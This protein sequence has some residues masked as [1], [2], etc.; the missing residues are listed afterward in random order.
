MGAALLDRDP[1]QSELHVLLVL[2]ARL[3][4]ANARIAGVFESR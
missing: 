3:L 4:A 1:L 2:G